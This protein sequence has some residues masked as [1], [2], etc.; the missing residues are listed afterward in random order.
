MIGFTGDNGRLDV[1]GCPTENAPLRDDTMN[2]PIEEA[3][4]KSTSK[5]SLGRLARIEDVVNMT[6]YLASDRADYMTGQVINITD[7]RKMN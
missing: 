5:V 3:G 6:C 2:L 7:G 1:D 4:K